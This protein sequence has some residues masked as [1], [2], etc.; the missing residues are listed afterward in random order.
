MSKP[1]DAKTRKQAQRSRDAALGIQRVEVRL[2][3]REREQLETLRSARAG[4]GEPYSADE[5]IS[6]LLRRDWERWQRQQAELAK[7]T[8]PHCEC[9]LPAG[10]GGAFK[11]QPECWHT[12][13]DKTLAL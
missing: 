9:S 12:Q 4:S 10:C 7:Q 3:I 5:Y 2:S 13:G 1:K 8:C 11:G 6:T